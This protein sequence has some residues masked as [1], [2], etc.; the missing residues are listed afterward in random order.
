MFFVSTPL[1]LAIACLFSALTIG[2]L[3]RIAC[4]RGSSD[5]KSISNRNSL[6]SWWGLAV[7]LALAVILDRTGVAILLTMAGILS[8]RE[9]LRLVGTKQVGVPTT[10]LVYSVVPVYYLLALYGYSDG[11]RTL[12]P[13]FMVLVFGALR[14]SIGQIT[15]Y[16]RTTAGMTWGLLLFVYCLSH[17]LF[18]FELPMH[19]KPWVGQAGWF[20][21]LVLLTEVNDISQALVGRRFGRTKLTPRIS[22]NKSLEGL[23]GGFTVTILLAILMAP[24]LTTFMQDR[25][26]KVGGLFAMLSGMLI[27]LFGFLGDINKSGIKR[28]VGVKDSGTLLPGQGGMMD[29]IDSLT[30]SAPV[31]YYFVAFI[32][33]RS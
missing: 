9:Y 29:R 11:L 26:W 3:I 19:E 20:L 14:A 8:L 1:L 13:I 27:A 7:A 28:D 21:Y 16:I 18:L 5:D 23:L 25:S 2:T 30:F 33:V 17:A 31:F 32:L 15:E 24:W 4:L 22:P 12:A 10:A 6:K